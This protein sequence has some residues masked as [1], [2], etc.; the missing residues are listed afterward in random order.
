[1]G[2]QACVRS[3]VVRLRSQEYLFV[4]KWARRGAWALLMFGRGREDLTVFL[5]IVFIVVFFSS[6][7]RFFL[8]NKECSVR[9]T[10]SCSL[11]VRS[12][13]SFFFL[14][15]LNNC[16]ILLRLKCV[17]AISTGISFLV[18]CS[19]KMRLPQQPKFIVRLGANVNKMGGARLH[20]TFFGFLLGVYFFSR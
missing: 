10:S 7:L 12:S 4:K 13:R 18:Q 17:F 9:G 1:M 11:F 8:S 15:A 19:W 20:V 5:V 16:C 14:W 2:N 3:V 6:S